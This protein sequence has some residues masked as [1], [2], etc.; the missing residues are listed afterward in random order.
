MLETL[1]SHR[2]SHRK[3]HAK[4]SKEQ[5]YGVSWLILNF[6]EEL[7]KS[8]LLLANSKFLF[9]TGITIAVV[10]YYLIMFLGISFLLF[11]RSFC[12]FSIFALVNINTFKQVRVLLLPNGQVP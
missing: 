6:K 12:C 7:H 3:G 11:F 10:F 1:T 2:K 9:V 4:R 8:G 5:S